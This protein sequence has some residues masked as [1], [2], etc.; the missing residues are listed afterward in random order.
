MIA[1]FFSFVIS[2]LRKNIV[3]IFFGRDAQCKH[4]Q[5]QAGKKTFYVN[6]PKQMRLFIPKVVYEN[7]TML[8]LIAG[9]K[10]IR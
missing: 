1:C 2:M 9:L 10:K 7:E 5:Q 6:V 3:K 8:Q 4:Y